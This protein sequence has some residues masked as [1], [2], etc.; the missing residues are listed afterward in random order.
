MTQLSVRLT[1]CIG[2]AF[3]QPHKD[4]K[5]GSLSSVWMRGGRGSLK[6][7]F[8]AIEIV[9]GIMADP[10]ANAICL[11]KVGDTTRTSTLAQI[12]WAIDKLEVNH[13]WHVTVSPAEATYLPTGQMILFKGLDDPVKLKSVKAVQGYFKFLWFEEAAEFKGPAEMRNVRQSVFRGGDKFVEFVSYNPP[14]DPHHWINKEAEVKKPGRETY[15]STYKEAPPEWLGQQFIEDAE[16]LRENNPLA[17]DNEYMGLPVGNNEAIIFAGRYR[18][19][20]FTPQPHW[21]GPY[22]GLDWG[23]STD[24]MAL[25]KCWI[26]EVGKRYRLYIEYENFGTSISIDDT[27]DFIREVP[28]AEQNKIRADNSRPEMIAHVK[29]RNFNIEAA[30]KWPGSVEDGITV[31]KGFVEIVIHTRCTHMQEEARLYSYKIDKLTKDVLPDIV[32]KFNHGWDAV[33]YAL[34]KYIKRKPKGFLTK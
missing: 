11:R 21:H 4:I 19:A 18:V 9:L 30:D 7:S 3:Y 23:F 31:L 6:S 22:Y 16:W 15:H 29:S 27:P 12:R 10:D 25:V 28:G 2:P 8:V 17:Y 26:E 34:A 32:D 24:P 14:P 20:E 5:S 13:L 33:R 1:D